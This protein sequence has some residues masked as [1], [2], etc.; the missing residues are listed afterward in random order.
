ME[1]HAAHS[2]REV[3]KALVYSVTE[4][5]AAN[6]DQLKSEIQEIITFLLP[7][8][9]P[10]APP[11]NSINQIMLAFESAQR[12]G[13]NLDELRD[14]VKSFEEIT[15]PQSV[16]DLMANYLVPVL[17]DRVTVYTHTLSE[18]VLGVLLHLHSRGRIN[19]VFVTESRPNNDGWTTASKLMIA[20]VET[21]LTIDAGFPQAVMK[22]DVMLSGSEIINQDGSVV[23]KVGV[24]PAAIFCQKVSIP[25]YIVA[26]TDKINPFDDSYFNF[27]PL[28]S[29][30]LGLTG[31][32]D[33]LQ[34]TGSYFD[35]TPSEFVTGYL[36]ERG[37]LNA[38]D[39]ALAAQQ[40]PV[41]E[42][43][44]IQLQTKSTLT[45]GGKG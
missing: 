7:V 33:G 3:M 28:T 24:Y 12:H 38:G 39:V 9:P 23:C 11:L 26:D 43:L 45:Q 19:R 16:H 21:L 8:L 44:K 13:L 41:S 34:V 2:G 20:G 32:P 4:S 6:L 17:P 31:V 40:R 14:K 30:D 25:V 22:S 42:W 5:N 27:T 18:T 1:L 37:L 36:T 35:I 29:Q 10:Y 15:A